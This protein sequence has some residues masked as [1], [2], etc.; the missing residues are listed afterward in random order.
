[1]EIAPTQRQVA[2]GLVKHIQ[3]CN[4][5]LDKLLW[6]LLQI[7]AYSDNATSEQGNGQMGDEEI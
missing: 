5:G 6:Q 2:G 4:Q 3:P 7:C 1:M